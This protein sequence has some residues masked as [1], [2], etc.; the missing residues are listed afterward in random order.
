MI[1]GYYSVDEISENYGFDFESSGRLAIGANAGLEREHLAAL[2][3]L[4][5]DEVPEEL[6]DAVVEPGKDIFLEE[7]P[8][9]NY[10]LDSSTKLNI[11]KGYL[12]NWRSPE[13]MVGKSNLEGSSDSRTLLDGDLSEV[14]DAARGHRKTREEVVKEVLYSAGLTPQKNQGNTDLGVIRRNL[15]P[16]GDYFQ[17]N[18]RRNLEDDEIAYAMLKDRTETTI[19]QLTELVEEI[20]GPEYEPQTDRRMKPWASPLPSGKVR[21]RTDVGG[22]E[23]I[24][25]EDVIEGLEDV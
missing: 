19:D 18:W 10:E 8:E 9:N 23:H 4:E 1:L 22:Y 17:E 11:L 3:N 15:R 24:P 13:D 16:E 20:K 6:G 7:K 5:Y 14:S 2:A 21:I 25:V 12:D